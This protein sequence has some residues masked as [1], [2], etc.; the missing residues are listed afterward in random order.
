MVSGEA[1]LD[2]VITEADACRGFVTSRLVEACRGAA[3]HFIGEQRS[4]TYR[5]I[6]GH[7]QVEVNSLKAKHA[8]ICP[9]YV[10]LLP[11]TLDRVFS[12]LGQAIP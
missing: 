10:E 6:I 2:G 3:L 11:A 8:A 5:R 7:L 1:M 12:N 9:T 4:Y